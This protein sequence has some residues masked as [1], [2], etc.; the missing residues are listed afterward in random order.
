MG[1]LPVLAWSIGLGGD[2]VDPYGEW[3]RLSGV[4]EDG[5][6]LVRPD[7]VVAFRAQELSPNPEGDLLR[8]LKVILSL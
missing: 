2:W 3:A 4:E 1:G 8:V 7:R 6:V 5:C